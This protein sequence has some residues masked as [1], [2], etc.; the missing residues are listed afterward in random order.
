MKRAKNFIGV[1]LAVIM[2]FAFAPV[3]L[4]SHFVKAD[5]TPASLALTVKN[6]GN[7]Y[8]LT[9]KLRFFD[10]VTTEGAE[11]RLVAPNGET[12]FGFSRFEAAREI[13]FDRVG[14][15]ALQFR[16][17][18]E[19]NGFYVYS[20]QYLIEVKDNLDL[21]VFDSLLVPE[22]DGTAEITVPNCAGAE[23]KVYAPNGN[24]CTL[25]G[26]KFM[27]A[28]NVYGEYVVEYSRVF[29]LNG[30]S[31]TFYVSKVVKV[32]SDFS[33]NFE[34]VALIG[35]KDT[36]FNESSD[37]YVFKNYDLTNANLVDKNGNAL[38]SVA[39]VAILNR[40]TGK[41]YDFNY[42]AGAGFTVSGARYRN[43]NEIED[44]KL[45][46]LTG[47]ERID[48]EGDSICFIYKFTDAYGVVTYKEVEKPAK[49][50]AGALTLVTDKAFMPEVKVTIDVN[51]GAVEAGGVSLLPFVI[52]TFDFKVE[53][54]YDKSL[55]DALVISKYL[56]VVAESGLVYYSTS[57][58]TM[59][60][61]GLDGFNLYYNKVFAKTEEWTVNF[62]LSFGENFGEKTLAL[63]L[64]FVENYTDSVSPT[65]IVP[66][67][68]NPNL[69]YGQ[70][71]CVP[72]F[73]AVDKNDSG[74]YTLG[75]NKEVSLVSASGT[76]LG[77]MT[78][79]KTYTTAE[80]VALGVNFGETYYLDFKAVD[81]YGNS[82][83]RRTQLFTHD[84]ETDFSRFD[85]SNITL[86]NG[87]LS[88]NYTGEID[89]ALD[90]VEGAEVVSSTLKTNAGAGTASTL[91][92]GNEVLVFARESEYGTYYIGVK[93]AGLVSRVKF[94][95]TGNFA[96]ANLPMVLVLGTTK[97]YAG[98]SVYYYNEG[99]TA[100]VYVQSSNGYYTRRGSVF[101]FA[102]AGEYKIVD[103][104]NVSKIVVSENGS[105]SLGSLYEPVVKVSRGDKICGD[106][107]YVLGYF[108]YSL[109]LTIKA[110]DGTEY[111]GNGSV[112]AAKL[113]NYT[114]E[115]RAVVNGKTIAQK[116]SRLIAGNVTNPTIVLNKTIGTISLT[117]E[118][119]KVAIPKAAATSRKG[120][121]VTVKVKVYA[122][123]GKELAVDENGE[124]LLDGVGV[125]K[126]YYTAED[127]EGLSSTE[128]VTFLV[129][130]PEAVKKT[131]PWWAIVL[132]CVG[133]AGVLG[134]S[135]YFVYVKLIVPSK[136]F[137]RKAKNTG[138]ST[139]RV[140]LVVM[141]AKR[142]GKWQIKRGGIL[143]A[144]AGSEGEATAKACE[145]GGTH[146]RVKVYNAFGRLIN[147]IGK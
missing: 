59:G 32:H 111:V 91:T 127:A 146:Y 75:V 18:D 118:S 124:V 7:T 113:S 73:S 95:P 84:T 96:E 137:K 85:I 144:T 104:A 45:N 17:Y 122:P 48:E 3:G 19:T 101:T 136:H 119:Q 74:K 105:Y 77:V 34:R 69:V 37:L 57:A 107:Y 99:S 58:Y 135:G 23:V 112:D 26:N 102:R 54:G 49:F 62:C 134:V 56:K 98:Q 30:K 121:A 87:E 138:K 15:Y 130:N 41:Y 42:A 131:L 33:A 72:D 20:K 4:V 79:G 61:V 126:I 46:T 6:A 139:K 27:P 25:N 43:L 128:V 133:S 109:V 14:V 142:G 63:A 92:K 97:I 140:E 115:A 129:K 8:N 51:S 11:A 106:N 10:Y 108:G 40:A 116:S 132:I 123:N 120:E 80:L 44:F 1:L 35:T 65:L 16:I 76:T 71:F 55:F 88:F 68:Y 52:P 78:I 141:P 21:F 22:S 81:A 117:D 28:V 82:R 31:H 29:D 125:Y 90:F 147:Q 47:I 103:G 12:V 94:T 24:E 114:L 64:S 70:D 66:N 13:G 60:T 38:E 143:V 67:N 9:E 50:N 100:E 36:E 5:S 83:M 110:T 2:A 93:I 53:E 145:L 39:E 86:N 89:Y